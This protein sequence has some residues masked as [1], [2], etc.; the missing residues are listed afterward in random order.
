[1]RTRYG[2]ILTVL[3]AVCVAG[4]D[5]DSNSLTGPGSNIACQVRNSATIAIRNE[6]RTNR[7]YD[8]R[9]DGV[10]VVT[11]IPVGQTGQPYTIVA[12]VP[13]RIDVFYTVAPITPACRFDVIPVLCSEEVYVCRN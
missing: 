2:L 8:M 5:G 1:M 6:S 12:G 4:C 13:R 11:A 7:A 9:V 3:A 10:T